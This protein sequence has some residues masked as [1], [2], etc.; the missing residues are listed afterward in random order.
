[1]IGHLGRERVE[2]RRSVRRDEAVGVVF[3]HH[4]IVAPRHLDD[5]LATRPRDRDRGGV[6]QRR[7][8][9]ERLGG[10]PHAGGGESRGIDP[11][12]VHRQAEELQPEMGRD[13]ACA[14]IG[15]VF[16]AQGI[17]RLAKGRHDGQEGTVSAR[18]DQETIGGRRDAAAAEPLQ[19][20]L[21][22][23]DRSS[24]ALIAEKPHEFGRD[25]HD[26]VPHPPEA[27]RILRLGRQV[28]AE[29]DER[30]PRRGT[31]RPVGVSDGLSPR[32]SPDAEFGAGHDGPVP[33]PRRDQPPPLRFDIA[34]RHG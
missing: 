2:G 11:L 9:I 31:G 15:Q 6:E 33:D 18:A 14:R 7:V 34:A 32:H 24:E 16:A 25:G 5:R 29:I 1:M 4:D 3:D 22:V 26:P 17:A 21:L 27:L 19:R 12:A 20:R 30:R 28:H 8:E 23:V 13:R 10:V